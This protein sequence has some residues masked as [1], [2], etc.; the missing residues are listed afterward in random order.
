MMRGRSLHPNAARFFSMC[1]V[2]RRVL[3]VGARLFFSVALLLLGHCA[4]I[5]SDRVEVD[6]PDPDSETEDVFLQLR[7][8]GSRLE[9]Q[10]DLV[11][12]YSEEQRA[13]A[14]GNVRL[15]F[16][17]G[18]GRAG[19]ELSA[20]RMHL[21]HQD[22]AIDMVVDVVLQASDSVTVY[23]DS[24]RWQPEAERL[25]VPG[26]LR[27]ELADGVETGRGLETDTS[28]DAWVLYDVEGR[29]EWDG[30]AVAIW[31]KR[32]RSQRVEGGVQVRY[33][34]AKL[35]VE[36]MQLKSP[37]VHWMPDQ[38]Q[39]SLDGGV[40]GVD[41]SGA[42]SAQQV[43]IDVQRDQL[44]ARGRIQV[45]R[46]A[47]LLEAD[48]WV[49]QWR[50]RHSAVRGDPARYARGERSVEGRHLVYAR[51]AERIEARGAVL[52]AEGARRLAASTMVYDHR[53]QALVAG[54]GVSVAGSEW[55]GILRSD[56]LSFDLEAERG[57][58][59]GLPQLRSIEENDLHISADSMHFDMKDRT[60]E[61][62]GHYQL[63][64]GSVRVDARQ[65]HYAAAD[66]QVVFVGDVSL[67]DGAID[68]LA[69]YQIESDTMAVQLADGVATG[70]RAAGAFRG[71]VVMGDGNATSWLVGNR[72]TVALEADRLR[73]L[74]LERDADVTYR[75]ILKDQV[76]RFRGDE[77]VLHFNAE[78]LQQVR[79]EGGAVL[80]S[81]LVREA[82]DI[83]VNSVKG[84]EMDIYFAEGLLVRVEVGPQAEGTY[85]PQEDIP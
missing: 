42:F 34:Q 61:G 22:G 85:L 54:G 24:L 26:T 14:T 18:A 25:V 73:T 67:R 76:S 8:P 66:E 2:L 29:W 9:I 27:I 5:E 41:S 71:R 81:R 45:R 12:E 13:L 15:G 32:E 70:V 68:T 6:I 20:E 62:M 52:F 51:D 36:D 31:A 39:L 63:T 19:A 69:Q 11:R 82:G 80:E 83:A 4:P 75:H 50:S 74:T 10:A 47:V 53:G 21:Y 49:E 60:I 3:L 1:A 64:S 16:F 46:G 37:L 79:V 40:E 48:E 30:E 58:L 65:G 23:A 56:S 17:N 38:R 59:L 72:G 78:G 35:H 33:E 55:Q 57:A 44:R 7:R 43:D 84:E 28:A 77:M